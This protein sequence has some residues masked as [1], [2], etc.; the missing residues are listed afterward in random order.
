[1]DIKEVLATVRK[2]VDIGGNPLHE[3]NLVLARIISENRVPWK[4][5]CERCHSH[6]TC[7]T[8]SLLTKL[9]QLNK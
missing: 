3:L 6:S 1:M 9:I 5:S 2:I 7:E 4:V 8:Y